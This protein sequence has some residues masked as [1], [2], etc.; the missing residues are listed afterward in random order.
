MVDED[1]EKFY[2]LVGKI[3]D[4]CRKRRQI[5]LAELEKMAQEQGL[6][7]SAILEELALSEDFTVDLTAGVIRCR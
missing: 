1:A 2:T 5:S 4:L 3:E 6:R 7:A